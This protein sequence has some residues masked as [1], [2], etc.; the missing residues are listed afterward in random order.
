M[1]RSV[2][3]PSSGLHAAFIA[4]PQQPCSPPSTTG[5][6]R[7]YP[8][9]TS[10]PAT[11]PTARNGTCP[12]PPAPVPSRWPGR[13]NLLIPLVWALLPPP[14]SG[15]SLSLAPRVWSDLKQR[16]TRIS[17]LTTS[18]QRDHRCESG[19]GALATARRTRRRSRRPTRLPV[20][21]RLPVRCRSASH[22][23]PMSRGGAA[24]LPRPECYPLRSPCRAERGRT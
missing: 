13:R 1:T 18:V 23:A 10:S 2:R 14:H 20:T 11:M 24:S 12:R 16:W 3:H 6:S 21:L 5:S 4:G 19:A 22:C 9:T 7:S 15:S 17:T 8:W